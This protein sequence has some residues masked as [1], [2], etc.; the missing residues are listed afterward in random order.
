MSV[1]GSDII[2]LTAENFEESVEFYPIIIV[3]FYSSNAEECELCEEAFNNFQS[4][5]AIFKDSKPP[6]KFAKMD[7]SVEEHKA[8]Y[9]KS[10]EGMHKP[11]L[12]MLR[13]WK[14]GQTLPFGGA[15]YGLDY[16]VEFLEKVQHTQDVA[17]LLGPLAKKNRKRVLEPEGSFVRDLD[18]E[19][20]NATVSG[21]RTT[22]VTFVQPECGGCVSF[23]PVFTEASKRLHEE[24]PEVTLGKV[25]LTQ[26]G[27][28][29]LCRQSGCTSGETFPIIKVFHGLD[30]IESYNGP[31]DE[32]GFVNFV[33][34]LS[35][36]HARKLE[37]QGVYVDTPDEEDNEEESGGD[38]TE[39]AH[40]GGEL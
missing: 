35:K 2:E 16:T 11:R 23:A 5:S 26:K 13:T 30:E 29:Q 8:L 36:M 37:S 32:S 15:A 25:D 3:H 34:A 38:A 17:E 1:M 9:E 22:V 7:A 21:A 20:F 12:P 31:R 10:V 6:V 24:D 28:K 40:D 33:K 39:A 18:P 19:T 14:D 4:A 27:H